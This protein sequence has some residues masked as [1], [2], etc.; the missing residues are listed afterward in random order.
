MIARF[1]LVGGSRLGLL[2]LFLFRRRLGA[3][4]ALALALARLAVS[5]ALLADGG[6]AVRGGGVHR[7]G[8]P[9]GTPLGTVPLGAQLGTVRRRRLVRRPRLRHPAPLPPRRRR[10]HDVNLL[11]PQP[12]SLP[13]LDVPGEHGDEGPGPRENVPEVRLEV[14][15]RFVERLPLRGVIR[16]EAPVDGLLAP[17]RSGGRRRLGS[18]RARHLR[19]V[20][21][22]PAA[23]LR[24]LGLALAAPGRSLLGI[25][26]AA[27]SCV[28]AV[29]TLSLGRQPRRDAVGPPRGLQAQVYP[30]PVA[31]RVHDLVL[32]AVG[33][34]PRHLRGVETIDGIRRGHL[35]GSA[36]DAVAPSA[37]NLAEEPAHRH[38]VFRGAHAQVADVTQRLSPLARGSAAAE[39]FEFRRRDDG[40][41][42]TVPAGLGVLDLL[43]AAL[44]ARD[45]RPAQVAALHP[46]VVRRRDALGLLR[47]RG[48]RRGGVGGGVGSNLGHG[49]SQAHRRE[50]DS[51]RVLVAPLQRDLSGSLQGTDGEDEPQGLAELGVLPPGPRRVQRRLGAVIALTPRRSG[52]HHLDLGGGDAFAVG[53]DG[54]PGPEQP[55]DE[56][57]HRSH[58]V[59]GDVAAV[60]GVVRG[61]RLAN[62]SEIRSRGGEQVH[63]YAL[64][65]PKQA[66]G[67]DLLLLALLLVFLRL[68]L[69]PL[70]LPLAGAF[71]V[72]LQK[73][74]DALEHLGHDRLSLCRVDVLLAET[75]EGPAQD[76]RLVRG[77]VVPPGFLVEV[78]P[79][80]LG[81]EP[82]ELQLLVPAPALSLRVLVL[83]RLRLRLRSEPHASIL[84]EVR[85]SRETREV[86]LVPRQ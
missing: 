83:P 44:P 6:R 47:R 78:Y 57:L 18:L 5:L 2:L 62:A 68:L 24:A 25:P 10:V 84:E 53:I 74:P 46:D 67:A 61:R 63:G 56:I 79:R 1:R 29:D 59:V 31:V 30:V 14:S 75:L 81:G 7:L 66:L 9:L 21:A 22:Q 34:E 73:R 54:V 69:A 15:A 51:L 40:K 32:A 12:G 50:V 26:R 77:L 82:G 11:Q 52:H 20:E 76:H 37:A 36:D 19:R 85:L 60:R 28:G 42:G 86:R 35:H 23:A 43:V 55:D 71:D 13:Q 8:T 70:L 72:A 33:F 27:A 38:A 65:A 48:F 41:S 80:V 64:G 58:R 39:A 17:R 4:L 3:A 49:Q 16:P 45:Q